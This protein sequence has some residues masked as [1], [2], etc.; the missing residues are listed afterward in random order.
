[1]PKHAAKDQKS[2]FDEEVPETP[3]SPPHERIGSDR[4][5]TYPYSGNAVFSAREPGRAN[6]LGG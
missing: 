1:M 3:P 2:L 5:Q 6:G 4:L